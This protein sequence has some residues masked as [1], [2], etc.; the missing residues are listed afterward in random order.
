MYE[1]LIIQQVTDIFLHNLSGEMQTSNCW[2][3]QDTHI[4]GARNINLECDKVSQRI[5][6]S[7]PD[8]E[9]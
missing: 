3:K 2:E 7:R 8:T 9:L 4:S 6:F 1:K 5:T